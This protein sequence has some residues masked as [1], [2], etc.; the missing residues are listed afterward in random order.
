[1][2]A[3]EVRIVVSLC[4]LD[5]LRNLFTAPLRHYRERL[6]A[7]AYQERTEE[8]A[9]RAEHRDAAEHGEQNDERGKIEATVAREHR[10]NEVVD[11]AMHS[12]AHR[13]D[14]PGPPVLSGHA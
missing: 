1:M 10:P 8:G 7:E 6:H 5:V 14:D 3:T 13:D 2:F 4:G 12:G 9:G 11:E